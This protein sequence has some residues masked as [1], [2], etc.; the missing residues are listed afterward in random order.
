M[1]ISGLKDEEEQLVRVNFHFCQF[2]EAF[3]VD[4]LQI[5]LGP[6]SLIPLYIMYGKK[7][8]KAKANYNWM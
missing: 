4:V 5:L 8:F 2:F 6:F 1:E 7:C 3:F